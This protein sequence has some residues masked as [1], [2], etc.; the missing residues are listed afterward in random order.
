[1]ASFRKRPVVIEAIQWTGT[2]TDEVLAFGNTGPAP[3]WGD[4]FK[5]DADKSEVL[6]RTLESGGGWFHVGLNDWIIRGVQGEFY[7]CK[8]DVFEAT[9]EPAGDLLPM[10]DLRTWHEQQATA[11]HPVV[12]EPECRKNSCQGD[13]LRGTQDRLNIAN[14]EKAN[15]QGALERIAMT[16]G[17]AGSA[18]FV[19]K[20][21]A[22]E[23][24]VDAG[25]WPLHAQPNGGERP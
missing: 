5:I 12:I 18:A 1:M 4:D 7:G 9:Y 13:I 6:I 16:G 15:A 11:E 19:M 24:L 25:L 14:N 2:N 22:T 3:L 20:H 8:P 10:T 23:A 21:I 17:E